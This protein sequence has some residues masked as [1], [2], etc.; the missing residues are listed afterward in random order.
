M[1]FFFPAIS[2]ELPEQIQA[3]GSKAEKPGVSDTNEELP[4]HSEETQTADSPE[5]CPVN[6]KLKIR[7]VSL[8]V[9][10]ALLL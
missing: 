7:I 8:G 9:G 6:L 10:L 2:A 5:R 4:Q 1:C 3:V